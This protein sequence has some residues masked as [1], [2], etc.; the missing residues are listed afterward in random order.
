MCVCILRNRSEISYQFR[1]AEENRRSPD[2]PWSVRQTGVYHHHCAE[3]RFDLFI[4]LHPI[5]DS[6]FEQQVTNL[7]ILQ[8][9]QAELASLVENPYRL[10]I[11]PFALYLDNWRWYFRF[12][13]EQFQE[14]V[15]YTL[16]KP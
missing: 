14:K 1:Y 2:L 6:L 9:S 7:A 3:G 10:H 11:M 4:L 8:S 12:L 16:L 15:R 5:E 13:G